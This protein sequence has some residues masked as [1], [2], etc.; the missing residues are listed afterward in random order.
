MIILIILIFGIYIIILIIYLKRKDNALNWIEISKELSDSTNIL[1]SNFLIMIFTNQT[2]SEIS[3]KLPQ[4]D[5][6]S[7]IYDKLNNLYEAEGFVKNNLE[8]K[9]DY[10]CETFYLNL[11]Y[12]YFNSLLEK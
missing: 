3:S 10:D 9:I 5:F 7:Y 4:K 8:N 6:T 11:D 2:F 12:P 1:M